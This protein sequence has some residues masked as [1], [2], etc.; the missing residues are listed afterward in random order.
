[1]ATEN[2]RII[3]STSGAVTVRRDIESIGTASTKSAKGADLLKGALAGIFTGSA[4]AI[5]AKYGDQFT[6]I[7]NRLKLVTDGTQQLNDVTEQLYQLSNKTYQSFT[8]TTELYSRSAMALKQLGYNTKET[9]QFTETLAKATALSGASAEAAK[10]GLLQLSQGLASGVLRGEELNSVL[11]NIPYVAKALADGLGVPVGALRKMGAQGELTSKMLVE[12]F[13]RISGSVD[14][15]FS[16]VAPTISQGL[17]VIENGFVRLAGVLNSNTGVFGYVGTALVTIGNNLE[18]LGVLITPVAALLAAFGTRILL[19][20]VVAG[21]V[22]GTQALIAFGVQ[23]IAVGTYLTATAIP[24]VLA[25]TAALLTNPFTYIAIAAAAALA[26]ITLLTV[27][28][29]SRQ[30]EWEAYKKSAADGI[31]TVKNL[32]TAAGLKALFA[33]GKA[34][35]SINGKDAAN[36]IASAGR[37][38]ASA[39]SDA[40]TKGGTSAS[41]SIRK[42]IIDSGDGMKKSIEAGGTNAGTTLKTNVTDGGKKAGDNINTAMLRGTTDMTGKLHTTLTDGGTTVAQKIKDAFTSVGTFIKNLFAAIFKA[43][44]AP[45][46]GGT[47]AAANKKA[48]QPAYANGGQFTVG[49]RGGTDSQQVRFKATPGERV[50]VETPAQQKANDNNAAAPQV[51]TVPPANVVNVFDPRAMVDVLDTSAGRD[52]LYNWVKVDRDKIVAALGV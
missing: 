44:S 29:S 30:E 19:G 50:T 2:V 16:K 22:G 31:E 41:Q 21:I 27:Y 26:G 33:G 18:A 12:A 24:A 20:Y 6:N 49:G 15:D 51:V 43:A 10:A 23:I 1:M 48:S 11:E 39:M 46:D 25:F 36:G 4:I 38:A 7:Q 40:F 45:Q 13:K 3:V 34:E 5:L 9:M 47:S 37:N 14:A 8:G 35:I 32:F 28:L 17:Q 52:V 42:S